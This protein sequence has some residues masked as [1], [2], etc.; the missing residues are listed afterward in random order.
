[1]EGHFCISSQVP[2]YHCARPKPSKTYP[3]CQVTQAPRQRFQGSYGFIIDPAA[4]T[5]YVT[6]IWRIAVEGPVDILGFSSVDFSGIPKAVI[7]F[8]ACV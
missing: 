4:F 3:G 7:A 2:T 5:K 6:N 8:S 1:M